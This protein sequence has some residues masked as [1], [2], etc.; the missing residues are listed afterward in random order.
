VV[1]WLGC[2]VLAACAVDDPRVL[3]SMSLDHAGDDPTWFRVIERFRAAR[4][5]HAVL[6]FHGHKPGDGIQVPTIERVIELARQSDLP[7]L[8]YDEISTATRGGVALAIDDDAIDEWFALRDLLTETDTHVT[9]FVT[10]WAYKSPDEIDKLLT[11]AA[12]GHELEPHTVDHLHPIAYV[13]DHGLDAWIADQVEPSIQ[14]M[15]DA[16]FEP[17]VLAYP[18]G[19]RDDEIDRAALERIAAVRATGHYCVR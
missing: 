11:L 13:R 6:M 8:R 1:K 19:E 14:I 16:G 12:D 2:L 18:F 9:F 7:M 10:R 15:R 4:A 3:C 5:N 17:Q